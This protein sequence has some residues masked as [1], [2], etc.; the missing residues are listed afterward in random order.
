[1]PNMTMT[2]DAEIL[3]KAR[4][5]AVEHDTSVSALVREYLGQIADK[6]DRDIENTIAELD[7]HFKKHSIR[8]GK[9][10][11]TRDQLHER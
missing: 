8:I 7:R 5:F 2:I 10:T 9:K 4:K 1:M 6:E 11:W 3:K